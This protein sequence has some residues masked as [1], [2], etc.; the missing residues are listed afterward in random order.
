MSTH[1]KIQSGSVITLDSHQIRFDH[2][3]NK[4]DKV[5]IIAHGFF[6]SKDALLL[7]ELGQELVGVYDVI[8]MNFRGHGTSDGLF[9]W[10][11]KEYLD[12][13]AVVEY[14]KKQ[15]K[16]VGVIGFSLG[17]ATSII[18]ASKIDGI[19]TLISISG[20]TAFEKVEYRF[21][22]LDIEN[23]IVYSLIGEGR[24]G[25]GVRP[26]P[27]WLGKD[28]PINSVKDIKCPVFYIHGEDDWLIKPW[29]SEELYKNTP[30][31]KRLAIIKNGPHAEYLIRKNKKE[32]VG[33]IQD[34][35]QSTL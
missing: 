26:G 35:F 17:A 7:K 18:T 9:H 8:I 11:A 33:L 21:W 10:T 16:R 31:L 24:I 1:H 34:W 14:A 13:T 29:H 20:P 15:Y 19:D 32:T 22:E 25:K 23:D 30:T 5:V 4:S 12:L 2:Y 27:F 6:N 3:G 28:K